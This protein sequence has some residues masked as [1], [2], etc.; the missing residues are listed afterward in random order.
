MGHRTTTDHPGGNILVVIAS[1]AGSLLPASGHAQTI[2]HAVNVISPCVADTEFVDIG[3]DGNNDVALVWIGGIDNVQSYLFPLDTN[4][5]MAYPVEQG[6]PY[7]PFWGASLLNQ[8]DVGCWWSTFWQPNTGLR[9]IGF[10]RINSPSDTT[11]GWIEA[12][13]Y[14][15]PTS[16][17]DTVAILQVAYNVTPNL[18]LPAGGIITG[19]EVIPDGQDLL[20]EVREDALVIGNRGA[21]NGVLEVWTGLGQQVLSRTIPAGSTQQL[22]MAS[23]AAGAYTA[24]FRSVSGSTSR[25]FIR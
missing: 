11:F 22:P 4:L 20:L 5:V 2:V 15:D 3:L 21:K 16:C 12:D 14:G 23:L 18:P 13:F 1:C 9:Y 17:A 6:D 24:V 25:R 10:K 19:L 8:T 7:G